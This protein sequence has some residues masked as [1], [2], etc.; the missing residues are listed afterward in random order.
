MPGD[1][2]VE[3]QAA[4]ELLQSATASNDGE[5]LSVKE[6]L[7]QIELLPTGLLQ[8]LDSI[9]PSAAVGG[10][11]AKLLIAHDREDDAVPSEE[12]R[13]LGDAVEGQVELHQT[14][15]SFFSHVTPDKP[16]GPFTF[17]K[18]AFK[19][20]KYTYNLISVV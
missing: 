8:D 13:R 2:S 20:F 5:R 11:R 12:S 18:E 16:V 19:L 17:V 15:F 10:L 3:A 4:Y 7:A 14:E 6:A 9:S 1:L